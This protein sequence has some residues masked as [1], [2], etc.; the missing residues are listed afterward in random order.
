[1]RLIA[2]LL[3]V[4]SAAVAETRILH[5]EIRLEI[6][7]ATQTF[8]S[9]VRVR[10]EGDRPTEFGALEGVTA[11]PRET[12]GAGVLDVEYAGK[13]DAAVA[14]AGS[15]TWVAG[16][17][18]PGLISEKGSYLVRG[19][20]VPS[21]P[22]TVD[23]RIA[24]PA[25][26]RAVSIGSLV[27]EGDGFA[28]FKSSYPV[29]GV[30]VV[31]GPY[32]VDERV[33][34][35]V[36]CRTYLYEQDRK[37]AEVLLNSLEVEIPRYKSIFGEVPDKR[38]DVVENFF[39]TGY[40]FSNFTL[41][42]DTVIR[43]VCAKVARSRAKTLPA[44]YLDHELV[45]CWLGN[46]LH[47]AYEQGNWCEA[48]TTYYSNYGSARR[49]KTDAAYRRKVSRS[50]SLRVGP[51]NDYPLLQFKAKSHAFENDIGYGK[52]S[53]VFDMLAQRLGRE[54][55][56]KAVGHAL[57]EL[58]GQQIGWQ[59]LVASM[60]AATDEDLAAFFKPWLERTG[61]PVLRWGSVRVDGNRVAG[62]IRQTQEGGAYPLEIP[63][64]VTTAAGTEE[65]YVKTASK[66]SAFVFE[67]SAPPTRL[68]IDPEHKVFRRIP[69]ER[70]APCL[71]A[72]NTAPKKVGF[73]DA[74]LL[75]RLDIEAIEPALPTDAAVLAI[76][77]PDAVKDAMLAGARRQEPTFNLV[78][79]GFTFQGKPYDQPGDGILMSYARADAPGLPVTMYLGN[80]DAAY[81]RVNYLPYYGAHGW[82]LFRNG[83]PVARGE[84]D[85]DRATRLAVTKNRA[86][87]AETL[88][89]DLL[90]LTDPAHDGRRAGSKQS[91]DLANALRGRLHVTGLTV[92]PWPS[93]TVK[94]GSAG[95]R[96]IALVD[97]PTLDNAFYPFHATGQ[98]KRPAAFDRVVRH[99]AENPKGALVLL[100]EQGTVAQARA[101]EEKGAAAVAVVASEPTLLARGEAAA[102]V[103]A[104][105]PAVAATLRK[106][107]VKD[108]DIEDRVS[109]FMARHWARPLAI[110]FVYLTP[111][112]AKAVEGH[113]KGGVIRFEV[114]VSNKSTSNIVGVLGKGREPGILLSAHWDG[115]VPPGAADNAAG[116]AVV[117]HVAAQLK[118]DFDA[119][120]LKRPVVVALFGGEELGLWGSRQ[121]AEV[122][123]R[124]QSPV[125][126][127]TA[128]VNVD[129]I[130]SGKPG[131]VYLVG[132]SHHPAL[133]EAFQASL[134]GTDLA[135]G[136]D[137]DKFAFREGSDHWPLHKAGAPAVTVYSASYSTMNTPLDT[138]DTVDVGA[139]RGT[140]RAVYR[141]VRTLASR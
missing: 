120:R 32:V 79:Q 75:K 114:A 66:E 11:T 70:V 37:H 2:L 136:R 4:T 103:D 69:R 67:A 45:H 89:E 57:A 88:V 3:L 64:V 81:A 13:I 121:F 140:A 90:W 102:W 109:A 97:G 131:T 63:V 68:A 35:G 100:D 106:R 115:A 8:T 133:L 112:A 1:M 99:P 47:V 59:Q 126:K 122:M 18:T 14:K 43:Y 113:A 52:G 95:A 21:G 9:K 56:D 77:L 128:C 23:I 135:L 6:D 24:V 38:F 71:E 118:R 83:R 36:K 26:H 134:K 129:G 5:Q 124:P 73:G 107:R 111:A 137:I 92:L 105:P 19:F 48:L 58:G 42:G 130:G 141:T 22:C 46:Y 116:V 78:E 16:D 117:L 96:S 44:G 15:A 123:V 91:Y 72:V 65:H 98:P 27:D 101:Y 86:G 82:V 41:L 139:L 31:T 87:R 53:M 12:E 76:G 34:D 74:A 108:S 33:I 51:E 49:E 132:R 110:P 17:S 127:P 30:V 55:F 138:V 25:P 50:F 80:S 119:G 61:A 62:T 40:G 10:F 20:Y 39:A 60:D 28:H 93:V 29:D 85:G 94:S 7:P 84:W 54:K 104:L 125:A